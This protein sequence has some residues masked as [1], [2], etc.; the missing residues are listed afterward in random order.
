MAYRKD[1]LVSH[2]LQ[3]EIPGAFDDTKQAAARQR[4]REQLEGMDRDRLEALYWQ[5]FPERHPDHAHQ[6]QGIAPPPSVYRRW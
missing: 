3:H 6:V 1:T 2:L 5:A 4:R